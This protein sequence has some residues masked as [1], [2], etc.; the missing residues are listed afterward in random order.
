MEI[1]LDVQQEDL[2][3]V[4]T[5]L[6]DKDV[7][8]PFD[9]VLYQLALHK[10]EEERRA[11]VK[12]YDPE[13]RYEVGDLIFK[14]YPGRLPVGV[15]KFIEINEGVILR[16]E[17]VRCRSFGGEILLSYSDTSEFR[18][19]TE[20]LKKQKI[21]LLLPHDQADPPLEAEYITREMDP[22]KHQQPLIDRDF[23]LLRKKLQ[24]VLNRDAE[25]IALS[26]RVLLRG[27]LRPIEPEVI[28]RIKAFLQ[29]RPNSE[30]T[31]FMVENFLKIKTSAADFD[32]AC[33]AL[34]H[35]LGNE[36]KIDF[37][38]TSGKGWGKWHLNSVLYYLRK[39]LPLSEANP[40]AG[41]SRVQDASELAQKRKTLLDGLFAEENNRF[42]LTQREV[43]SGAVRLR[44]GL[45]DFAD[46]L[47]VEAVDAL[48]KKTHLLHYYKEDNILFGFKEVFAQGKA[49]QAMA[50]T[51][52]QTD[53]DSLVF[54]AKTIKRG[55]IANVVHYDQENKVFTCG[56]EMISSPLFVNKLMFLEPEVF[57]AVAEN[58]AQF[59]AID[60]LNKLVHKVFLEFGTRER[61]Y[62]LHFLKLYHILDLIYP[63]DLYQVAETVLGNPEFVPADKLPGVFYLDKDAVNEIEEEEKSRRQL[64][65][66][67]AR[68]KREEVL[69]IKQDEELSRQEELRLKREERRLKRESEMRLKDQLRMEK[70][71]ARETQRPASAGAAVRRAKTDVEV[72]VQM[73]APEPLPLDPAALKTDVS[74]RTK[75][76]T[77]SE[78]E[79]KPVKKGQKKVLEEKIELDE[80][81]KEIEQEEIK[82]LPE[83]EITAKK[84]KD[85][86]V[87][88]VYKDEGFGGIF[89][90]KLA[91][92]EKVQ[93]EPA[94][95]ARKKSSKK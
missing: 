27:K 64:V 74:K 61:N 60:T 95:A 91:E 90:S 33:F 14:E 50:L 56:E 65:V 2:Q 49:L 26:G 75:K 63:H 92:I 44:P 11:K 70:L 42:F 45:F 85:K 84:E 57:S 25:I 8:A 78:R 93:E 1:N 20:Y 67:E 62:E 69:K 15:K 41:R 47:E 88:V 94:P 66:S 46:N 73:V 10:T 36:Y 55:T 51:I 71:K 19:Y 5:Y 53:S 87:E 6:Q 29:E 59:R 32:S 80:I 23:T 17:E 35:L 7:P 18:K 43:I 16:V 76:K 28:E 58:I 34:N 39:N 79:S 31:E 22:R 24:S 72:P 86:K 68:K 21:D 9:D 4:K 30:T 89:A 81:R 83:K 12:K 38:Q 3:F 48:S 82:P 13:C 77:V 54:S 52:E 37:R 40:L